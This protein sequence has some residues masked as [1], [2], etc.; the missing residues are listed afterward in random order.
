[1]RECPWYISAYAVQ[2]YL[3]LTHQPIVTAG[4]EWGRAERELMKIAEKVAADVA[5][6]V[7]QA[8]QIKPGLVRYRGPRPLRLGLIVATDPRPEGDKPQLVDVLP[9]SEKGGVGVGS[10]KR[11]RE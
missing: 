2:R 4:P 3:A 9:S 10:K 8:R 7:K 1:M 5:A 11:R 6:G